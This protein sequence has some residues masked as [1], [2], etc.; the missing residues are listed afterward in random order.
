[1]VFIFIYKIVSYSWYETYIQFT[2][3]IQT[4]HNNKYQTNVEQK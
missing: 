3:Q 4:Q 2:K 1:M